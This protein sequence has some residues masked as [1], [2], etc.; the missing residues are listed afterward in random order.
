MPAVGA[1]DLIARL[2]EANVQRAV[3]LS[4]AYFGKAVGLT[5]DFNVIPENDY[6]AAEV[7]KYP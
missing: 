5:E 2:D 3:I 7:A 4:G 1:E 6:V